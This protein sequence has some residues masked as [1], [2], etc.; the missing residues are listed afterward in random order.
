M[1]IA[2]VGGN[3]HMLNTHQLGDVFHMVHEGVDIVGKSQH[4]GIG[5]NTHHTAAVGDGFQSL[6]VLAADEVVER[7]GSGVGC[8]NGLFGALRRLGAAAQ[9][10]V[11]HIHDDTHLV[12]LTDEFP[13]QIAQAAVGGLGAS[14]GDEVAAVV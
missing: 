2:V 3:T 11:G 9:A 6:V 14:V 12:H 13:A 4:T 8:H 7:T 10:G 1:D 5:E